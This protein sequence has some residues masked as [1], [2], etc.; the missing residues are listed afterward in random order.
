MKKNITKKDLERRY[1]YLLS[2]M[3]RINELLSNISELEHDERWKTIGKIEYIANEENL[4]SRIQFIEKYDKEY[5]F[6][7]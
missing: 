1:K 3:K 7:Q 6:F 5:N 4:K 2:E